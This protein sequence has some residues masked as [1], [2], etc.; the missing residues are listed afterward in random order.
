MLSI[1]Y[2]CPA[3]GTYLRNPAEEGT[4]AC[5]RDGQRRYSVIYVP[6][7]AEEEFRRIAVAAFADEVTAR[8]A[9]VVYPDNY[10]VTEWIGRA[11]LGTAFEGERTWGNLWLE[12]NA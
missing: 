12:D 11:G 9:S 5:L 2:E 7:V 1:G 6:D 3:C 8:L 10:E 4:H